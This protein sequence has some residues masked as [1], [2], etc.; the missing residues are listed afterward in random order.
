MSDENKK[1]MTEKQRLRASLTACRWRY[2]FLFFFI[3]I[4]LHYLNS[5]AAF[6]LRTNKC[7]F[8]KY[9]DTLC[10]LF[11][12]SSSLFILFCFFLLT[13]CF[14]IH[15]V[16]HNVDEMRLIKINRVSLDAFF[17]TPVKI[18]YFC[19]CL[20]SVPTGIFWPKIIKVSIFFFSNLH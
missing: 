12:F 15:R 11:P 13:N 17:Y 4:P 5:H 8:A 10:S 16:Q 20:D 19:K 3:G 14:R 1:Q 6:V 9:N 7:S 2:N 18:A